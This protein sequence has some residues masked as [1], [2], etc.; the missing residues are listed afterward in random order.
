[1][2]LQQLLTFGLGHRISWGFSSSSS[3]TSLENVAE[4]EKKKKKTS[5]HSFCQVNESITS[6]TVQTHTASPQGWA[7]SRPSWAVVTLK[8][9]LRDRQN[10]Y[11]LYHQFICPTRRA[12]SLSLSPPAKW[13]GLS[14]T[15]ILRLSTM[16]APHQHYNKAPCP[17]FRLVLCFQFICMT[18]KYA[19]G[20]SI[21][22][23]WSLG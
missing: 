21:P 22:N 4:K 7:T 2:C 10:D 14:C 1:M 12:M 11:A 20:L 8:W 18:C 3:K 6:N 13:R 19:S 17:H 15:Q 16:L 23:M 5:H 9:L